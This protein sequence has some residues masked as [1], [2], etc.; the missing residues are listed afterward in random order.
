MEWISSKS[1]IHV[2]GNYKYYCEYFPA[3]RKKIINCITINCMLIQ[4]FVYHD[5]LLYSDDR[6]KLLLVLLKENPYYVYNFQLLPLAKPIAKQHFQFLAWCKVI[7]IIISIKD[8][9]LHA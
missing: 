9:Q 6:L 1:S 5:L 7:S 3:K 8:K 2:A 4:C